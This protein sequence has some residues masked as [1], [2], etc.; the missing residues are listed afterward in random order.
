MLFARPLETHRDM[1]LFSSLP[2]H[3]YG[4][5]GL[6]GGGGDLFHLC[7][8]EVVQAYSVPVIRIEGIEGFLSCK[9]IE[10]SSAV[11]YIPPIVVRLLC[12]RCMHAKIKGL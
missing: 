8:L 6:G 9:V 11:G 7:F 12:F 4:S 1:P 10:K 2:G 3:I 5:G